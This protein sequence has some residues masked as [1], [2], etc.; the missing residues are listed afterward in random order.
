MAVEKQKSSIAKIPQQAQQAARQETAPAPVRRYRTFLAVFLLVLLAG[1]FGV[2]TFLVKTIQS[3]P[4]DLV[5][6]EGIQSINFAPFGSLMIAIS[7]LGFWPQSGLITLTIVVVILFYGLQWE[8]LSAILAAI[9]TTA[10]NVLVKD[11]IQRPRPSNPIIHVLARLT[12]FSFP[13]GH[14]MYYIGFYGFVGFLVFTLLKP[15]LLRTVLLYIVGGLIGLVGIS[16]I[17]EGQHWAS[18]VLG[19]YLLGTLAL[20]GIIMLYRWGK[21]RF[22]VHQP[23]AKPD[24][25]KA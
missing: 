15:S 6:T 4:I 25:P 24:S 3:F 1:G 13:S 21:S 20:I 14:V 11:L 18:D 9:L 23:V 7:W 22:F 19:A 2:L 8:A 16:R 12:D 10:V 17:Y 5:I